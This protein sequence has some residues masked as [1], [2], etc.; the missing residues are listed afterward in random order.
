MRSRVVIIGGGFGGLFAVRG[1][2][3]AE[4]DVTV[5]DRTPHHL[6]QPLLY[7]VATGILSEGQI[8][9]P[10]RDLL[11]RHSNVDCIGGDVTALD[12]ENRIVH[13]ERPGGGSLEL[14]YDHLVV[15]A[16]VR[17]SYFGHD[18]FAEHAPGMKTLADA[19]LIRRKLFGAFEMA[20]TAKDPI[21]RQRW[22]TFALVGGGPTGVELAGQI[23]ELATHTLRREFRR[24]DPGEARVLLFDG[25]EA[26]LAV[27]GPKLAGKASAALASLGVELHMHSMV[28]AVDQ[29]GLQVRDSSGATTRYE[30][31]TVLWAA[32]VAA[33]PVA[34]V[35]TRVCGAEQ[36]RAGRIKVGTDLTLPGHPEISV[37]GD[38]M[39][40]QELPGVAEVAMQTGFYAGRRIRALESGK[41]WTKPFDYHDL[42]SAAYISRGRAVVSFKGVHLSGKIGWVAWLGIHLMFLTSFRN[43]IG[44]LISWAFTFSREKRRERAFSLQAVVPGQDIYDATRVERTR[45]DVPAGSDPG[46]PAGPGPS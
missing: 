1:L 27:F 26:P 2:R 29:D 11:K 9:V 14:P 24:I 32:G 31:G 16:G 30:A 28:T 20:Q 46:P 10:L 4:V 43:R 17:Q 21:E 34:D 42:G 23:R 37:V 12:A 40:L 19:L 13:A 7:Q 45:A 15:A 3:G 38:V 18:E 39:S 8:A 33:A 5:V 36:D 22:L 35:V 25:G 6:F 44:A 41:T